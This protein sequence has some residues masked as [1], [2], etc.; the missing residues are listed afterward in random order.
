MVERMVEKAQA[1]E[2]KKPG[3]P[4]PSRAERGSEGRRRPGFGRSPVEGCRVRELAKPCRKTPPI[5]RLQK[6]I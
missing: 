6:L 5:G 4:D 3:Q 1:V 2:G